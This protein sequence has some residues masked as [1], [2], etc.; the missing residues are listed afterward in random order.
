MAENDEHE[1]QLESD[2][3]RDEKSIEVRRPWGVRS[4]PPKAAPPAEVRDE[5]DG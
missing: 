2:R 5:Q 3:E 4:S 1:E